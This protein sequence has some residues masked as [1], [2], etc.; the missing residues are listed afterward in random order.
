MTTIMKYRTGFAALALPFALFLP[1][2]IINRLWLPGRNRLPDASRYDAEK[3]QQGGV[4]ATFALQGKWWQQF[5]DAALDAL[6]EHALASNNDLGIGH[7]DAARPTEC[8]HF[9]T[10]VCGRPCPAGPAA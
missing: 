5:D 10:P 4:E 1:F 7:S 3:W 2:V 6:V 8:R 9:R